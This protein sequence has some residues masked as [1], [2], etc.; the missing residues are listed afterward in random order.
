MQEFNNKETD[1]E[2]D[3]NDL[4]ITKPRPAPP[5]PRPVD[6]AARLRYAAIVACAIAAI[7]YLAFH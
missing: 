5:I 2:L 6:S 7:L 1:I 4:P 3:E